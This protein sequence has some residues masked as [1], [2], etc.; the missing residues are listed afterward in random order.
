M[1][2]LLLLAVTLVSTN[3]YPSGD[4]NSNLKELIVKNGA[5]RLAATAFIPR[6]RPTVAGLVVA[7]GASSG[8][9]SDAMYQHLSEALPALG[10]AVLVFDR[11]GGGASLPASGRFSYDVLA[12]DLIAA[13]RALQS[14]LG[15]K[16]KPIGY[17]GYS[18]GGWIALLAANQD[19]DAAFVI[20]ISAPVTSPDVQM[21][22]ATRNILRIRGY[23]ESTQD[24]AVSVRT[25]VDN[26]ARGI[27]GR[28]VAQK[29]LDSISREPWFKHIYLSPVITD[30]GSRKWGDD[31]SHDPLADLKGLDVPTLL[32][33]GAQDQWI[34]VLVSVD[35]AMDIGKKSLTPL[36]VPGADHAMMTSLPAAD[37]IDPAKSHLFKPESPLYFTALGTWLAGQGFADVPTAP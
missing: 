32:V 30:E 21:I 7:H 24:L 36:I 29:S 19:P 34:P 31:I 20:S 26:H 16:L 18:Q 14:Q 25:M 2:I 27:V 35:R 33:Y 9:R 6:N 10:V 23:N 1:T 5:A 11:R 37:Q 13:R 15:S 8:L 17:W 12:S 28:E 22:T 3:A 4:P